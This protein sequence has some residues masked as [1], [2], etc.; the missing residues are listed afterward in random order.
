MRTNNLTSP[1]ALHILNDRHDYGT[2]EATLE[3][4]KPCS[5]GTSMNCW[6]ALYMQAF[7]QRN[8]LIEEQQVSDI[9]SLYEMAHTSRGHY[10]FR[11]LV[12]FQTVQQTY[13]N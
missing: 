8:I 10:A 6:E 4:L 9:N 13:T 11:N 3:L 12:S 1:Y 2:A 5:K 7:H